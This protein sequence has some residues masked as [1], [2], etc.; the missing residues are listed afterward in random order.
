MALKEVG[1]NRI[2]GDDGVRLKFVDKSLKVTFR[3][4]HEWHAWL[5][6]IALVGAT[7]YFFPD[8]GKMGGN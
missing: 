6:E 2:G 4:S 5:G 7:V 3:L 8:F 1:I